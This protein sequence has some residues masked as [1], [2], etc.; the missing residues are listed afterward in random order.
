MLPGG[1]TQILPGGSLTIV[2]LFVGLERTI[3][4]DGDLAQSGGQLLLAP[5]GVINNLAGRT[6]TITGGRVVQQH[7]Q[8]PTALTYNGGTVL[9]QA[10]STI[11]FTAPL[12]ATN[13][14]G[15]LHVAQGTASMSTQPHMGNCQ[16]DAGATLTFDG[17]LITGATVTGDGT[18]AAR[19]TF[20]GTIVD[21][22]TLRVGSAGYYREVLNLRVNSTVRNFVLGT[23]GVLTGVGNLVVSET[24]TWNP[25]QDFDSANGSSVE[26]TGA[27][28]IGANAS[29][30]TAAPSGSMYAPV[31]RLQRRALIFGSFN[32]SNS[33][34]R[35][36]SALTIEPG[37][38][39][40]ISGRALSM[41]NAYGG[42]LTN[43]GTIESDAGPTIAVN[44]TPGPSAIV[45]VT[46][47]HVTFQN[48]GFFQTLMRTMVLDG[49][50]A[51][52]Q[53]DWNFPQGTTVSGAGSLTI[54]SGESFLIAALNLGGQLTI[55]GGTLNL[56]TGATV[57][58]LTM[59]SGT[60]TGVGT[61]DVTG[62]SGIAWYGGTIA[63]T[64][65]MTTT[66][67]LVAPRFSGS[68]TTQVLGTTLDASGAITFDQS[69]HLQFSGG[70]LRA[71]AGPIIVQRGTATLEGSGA[72]VSSTLLTVYSTLD[73]GTGV[74]LDNQGIFE[75]YGR[76]T[77]RGPVNQVS[78]NS[79]S[80]TSISGWW[81]TIST[82]SH[83]A[84][85]DFVGRNITTNNGTLAISGANA[86]VPA[87]STLGTN[88]GTIRIVDGAA[89][90]FAPP[91]V[92]PAFSN[93]GTLALKRA[94]LTVVG[95]FTQAAAGTLDIGI[96]PPSVPGFLIVTGSAT[97]DGL[98]V[99]ETRDTSAFQAG[100]P[101]PFILAGS[102]IG[103]FANVDTSALTG[104]PVGTT[105]TV[106][107]GGTGVRLNFL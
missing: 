12:L 38:V 19:G 5:G 85:L 101:V 99:L 7:Y 70:T 54:D 15:V 25:Q 20:A 96:G 36:S 43:L 77:I 50:T 61:L 84:I 23:T 42:S 60:L 69:V 2:G 64:G 8:D 48:N 90:T 37:G 80:D 91:P 82:G 95:N 83:A 32:W 35:V 104:V 76:A 24:M 73:L 92:L 17:K 41:L 102:V 31:M 56:R 33:S 11:S 57:G 46:G 74:R 27:L 62:Q 75:T 53:G 87:L 103:Q 29:V 10:P 79:V 63:D 86:S 6:W 68:Q 66:K 28:I 39:L 51:I 52:F 67:L 100:T 45:H 93:T 94:T 65:H 107:Y 88:T 16:I 49:G 55:N 59:Y 47:G 34:I 14:T 105:P 4:N 1:T 30:S 44:Y 22:G 106:E 78:V 81:R 97:L 89:L 58:A 13:L 9:V 3:V 72:L 21:L 71:G 26:G 98:L 18:L 40:A